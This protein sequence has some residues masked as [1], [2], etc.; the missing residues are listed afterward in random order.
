MKLLPHLPT[1]VCLLAMPVANATD[2]PTTEAKATAKR[3][4]AAAQAAARAYETA[5]QIKGMPRCKATA[6][7]I[8]PCSVGLSTADGKRIYIGSP[9]AT[10]EVA[11]FLPTLRV[12]QTYTFPDAFLEFQKSR[13]GSPKYRGN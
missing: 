7:D 2:K 1:I 12:G 9:G 8:S 10:K 3:G 4:Q 11:A 5:E 13:R 6:E